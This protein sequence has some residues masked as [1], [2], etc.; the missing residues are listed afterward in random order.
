MI[1]R[2]QWINHALLD[3][4]GWKQNIKQL[5]KIQYEI[6]IKIFLSLRISSS[7][8]EN[9]KTLYDFSYPLSQQT[10]FKISGIFSLWIDSVRVLSITSYN[11][12]KVQR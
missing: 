1:S 4:K 10:Y 3:H 7:I 2:R 12:Y 9:E 5:K 8:C 6:V 11:I